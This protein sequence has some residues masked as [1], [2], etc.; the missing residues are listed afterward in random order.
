MLDARQIAWESFAQ[1]LLGVQ[2]FRWF[3][4]EGKWLIAMNRDKALF[5]DPQHDLFSHYH[6]TTLHQCRLILQ[7]G[8]HVG[9][10]HHG[11][12]TAPA[13]IWGT[14]NPGH[15]FDRTPL[16]RGWSWGR[17]SKVSGWDC[18]VALRWMFH[19]DELT[20]RT[21]VG[22]G[23]KSV[24]RLPRGETFDVCSRP[25]E[26]WL[27][28]DVYRRFRSI[29]T[30]WDDLQ[31]GRVVLCRARRKHPED[32]WTAGCA[33]PMT[34]CRVVDTLSLDFSRWLKANGTR[35]YRCPTCDYNY[36]R[37]CPCTD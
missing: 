35:Q 4:Q 5:A 28:R 8:F 27:N 25:T 1:E 15:S 9:K 2:N 16:R 37:G 33:A 26:V 18:P 3:R 24:F 36:N 23:T 14:N 19:S 11:S 20:H 31:F 10:F 7:D 13:G 17:E 30:H 12:K 21:P 6:G 34:C 29:A 32:I 22:T